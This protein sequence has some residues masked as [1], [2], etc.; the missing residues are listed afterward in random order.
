MSRKRIKPIIEVIPGYTAKQSQFLRGE[1]TVD[2]LDGRF[3]RKLLANAIAINDENNIL[4]A[5]D[6]I[7]YCKE[8]A[9]ER[10]RERS[11]QRTHNL[12][13]GIETIWE[14][15]KTTE[16]TEYQKKIIRDEIPLENVRTRDLV[17]IFKKANALGNY[18]L[19]GV[20]EDLILE[21]HNNERQKCYD[22]LNKLHQ[23]RNGTYADNYQERDKLTNWEYAVLN[24]EIDSDECSTEHLQH[25]LDVATK[26][27]DEKSVRVARAMLKYRLHPELL[28][29]H[30]DTEKALCSIEATIG[31]PIRRLNT[32]FENET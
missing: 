25:I 5:K 6:L 7:E 23:K 1:I 24:L 26:N 17:L 11:R 18:E 9:K 22:G 2:E 28:W 32:W 15:P 30:Q 29:L 20:F 27:N 3:F 19:A 10:N 21:R 16:Y 8:E 13:N 4:L 31:L 14:K 12:L